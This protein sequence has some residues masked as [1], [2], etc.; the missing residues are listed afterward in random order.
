[1]PNWCECDLYI[2]GEQQELDRFLIG[3]DPIRNKDGDPSFLRT[4][5]PMPEELDA[6]S[7]PMTVVDTVEEKE[8]ADPFPGPKAWVITKAESDA[9]VEKYGANNW[10]DWAK[11]HWGT[12]WP[13]AG[14]KIEYSEGVI[15]LQFST[16]WSPPSPGVLEVSKKF[17]N[18]RFEMAYFENGIGFTGGFFCQNGEVIKEWE[19]GYEG[20]RGG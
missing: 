15:L 5:Y 18:L 3:L 16:P 17:P 11:L 8:H 20:D 13:D 12:K 9:L 14:T 4:Y 2:K 10:Y 7:H 1:M 19:M 6:T